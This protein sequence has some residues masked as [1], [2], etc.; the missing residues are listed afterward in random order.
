MAGR[1]LNICLPAM[2]KA[3]RLAADAITYAAS[4]SAGLRLN[5]LTFATNYPAL[6]VIFAV[7]PGVS[8]P[9][10]FSLVVMIAP[11]SAVWSFIGF[12][13]YAFV[14]MFRLGP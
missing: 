4:F 3:I 9:P 2:G 14:K 12:V 11:S 7:L 1:V 13:I 8:I 10:F 6:M 5:V